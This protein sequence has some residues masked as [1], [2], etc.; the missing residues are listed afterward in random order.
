MRCYFCLR[1]GV[2][3]HVVTGQAACER[4]VC[5]FQA[6]QTVFIHKFVQRK[7]PAASAYRHPRMQAFLRGGLPTLLLTSVT[8]SAPARPQLRVTP[9]A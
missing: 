8:D 1:T 6:C 7:G 4:H 5:E 9:A 3:V 2:T